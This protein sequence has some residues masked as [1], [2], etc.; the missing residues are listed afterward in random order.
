MPRECAAF[1]LAGCGDAM[2]MIW[3]CLLLWIATCVP[4]M[5]AQLVLNPVADATLIE[6]PAG[7]LANGAATL[8]YAGRTG[9]NDGRSMRRALLRFDLSAIPAGATILGATLTLRLERTRVASF[10]I[11][12]HRMTAAWGEGTSSQFGGGG[13]TATPGD[14]TWLARYFG[15]PQLW[16]LPG[17]DFSPVASA[18]ALVGFDE[19]DYAWSS[20]A[21]A[22][23]VLGWLNSPASNFGWI[24]LSDST[25]PSVKA[26]VSRES[27]TSFLR[28]RLTI[29]YLD[30]APGADGDVPLPGWA[31]LVLALACAGRLARSM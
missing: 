13:T 14:A 28:P 11:H 25:V 2:Q 17:G 23:D 5:A 8:M 27:P 15:T 24:L 30:P 4:C 1:V 21:L 12:L 7:E 10:P 9:T 20:A 16:T 31:L 3:S 18:S 6:D 22:A 29:D 26:F 19:I